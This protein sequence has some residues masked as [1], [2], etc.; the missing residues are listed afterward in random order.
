[1]P[2]A[3]LFGSEKVCVPFWAPG[4]IQVPTDCAV[5]AFE[6]PA[7]KPVPVE[8]QVK[9]P[10]G[11]VPPVPTKSLVARTVNV[12]LPVGEVRA[13]TVMA[14]GAAVSTG[15]VAGSA[16]VVVAVADNVAPT[17]TGASSYKSHGAGGPFAVPLALGAGPAAATVEPR[18]GGPTTLVFSFSERVAALDGVLDGGE[19]VVSNASVVA[20]TLDAEGRTLTLTLAG[21]AD[22]TVVSVALL[23]LADAAVRGEFQR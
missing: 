4:P 12:T 7:A 11:M 2:Y 16:E 8:V 19:F 1:M 13:P 22:R 9:L 10:M 21:V 18:R 3:Q 15:T 20:A 5:V 6:T 17:I 14:T 23:D